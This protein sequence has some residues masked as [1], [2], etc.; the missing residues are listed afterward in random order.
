MELLQIKHEE[1]ISRIKRESELRADEFLREIKHKDYQIKEKDEQNRYLEMRNEEIR[2][3]YDALDRELLK[4]REQ[5]SV[6]TDKLTSCEFSNK[7]LEM[8]VEELE[9]Q[10]AEMESEIRTLLDIESEKTRTINSLEV[11]LT[12][13]ENNERRLT[14]KLNVLTENFAELEDHIAIMKQ[15]LLAADDDN[16]HLASKLERTECDLREK[17][18]LILEQS[19]RESQL[20]VEL[21]EH[22]KRESRREREVSELMAENERLYRDL[23]TTRHRLHDFGVAYGVDV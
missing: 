17:E 5:N 4:S 9:I 16:H 23:N 14:D 8:L 20:R 21:D 2:G 7:K 19:D 3:D 11:Q 1:E 22:Q 15:K 12:N 18:N 13:S 6:L 10:K